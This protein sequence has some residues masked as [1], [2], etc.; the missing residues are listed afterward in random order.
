MNGKISRFARNDI[1]DRLHRHQ[2]RKDKRAMKILA[3]NGLFRSVS[4]ETSAIITRLNKER[5]HTFLI[6]TKFI[7]SECGQVGFLLNHYFNWNRSSRD[8]I[9]YRTFFANSRFEALQGAVKIARHRSLLMKKKGRTVLIC[10]PTMEFAYL[11][12]PLA[13]GETKALIPGIKI[14]PGLDEL[15]KLITP[16]VAA[17]AICSSEVR[18]SGFEVSLAP[19]TP[20]PASAISEIL[21]QCRKDGIITILEQSDLDIVSD[22]SLIHEISLLPDIIVTGESLTDYEIPFGAFSMAETIHEPWASMMTCFTHSSTYS[23]NN[24][25]LSKV[26]DQLLAHAPCIRSDPAVREKCAAIASDNKERVNAFAKYVN[27]GLVKLYALTGLDI[28]AVGG[29]GSKLRIKPDDG[30]EKEIFDCVAG[31]GAVVRGHTPQDIVP[32]VIE[33]HEAETNYW[34]KL[35]ARLAGLCLPHVFPAVSGASA[36]DIGMTLAM[37]ANADKTKIVTFKGNYAGKTL[38]SLNCT[39]DESLREPFFP[40]YHDVTYID[41]F[42]EDAKKSLESVLTSGQVALIWFEVIQGGCDREIPNDLIEMMNRYK[43]KYGYII[44]TDEI[45][46][47]FFRTGSLFSFQGRVIAPD[48]VTLAKPLSDASFPFAATM[49]SSRVYQQAVHNKPDVVH[50]LEKLYQNQTGSHIALHSVEKILSPEFE[51]NVLKVSELLHKGLDDIA[52][53]SS[54]VKGISG[55]GLTYRLDY[56]DRHFLLRFLGKT[57]YSLFV[58]YMCRLCVRKAD[59]FLFFDECSP[60]LTVSDAEVKQLLENLRPVFTEKTSATWLGFSMFAVK[61]V[62]F[63]IADALKPAAGEN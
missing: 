29:H 40:L 3:E 59:A 34:E 31:G 16:D 8:R 6:P 48:I 39:A 22:K 35:S 27:P 24:L 4:K 9:A 23:G 62:F 44:A 58:L 46:N 25:S 20:N 15:R 21:S 41:P 19:R 50:Y 7:S 28:H 18:G 42:A 36:V 60:A 17:V 30:P 43:D 51:K 1:K 57:G 63:F 2:R 53:K 54:V 26:R 33:T 61:A 45:F 49:V 52:R 13:R 12:D 5:K 38:L 56:N 14:V 47:G 11:V 55:R 37:L 10:D 32:E